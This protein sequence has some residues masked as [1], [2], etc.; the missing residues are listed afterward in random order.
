MAIRCMELGIP[1][2]IG[3]GEKKYNFFSKQNRIE[4]NCQ[5]KKIES[6]F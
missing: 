4:I 2:A 6:L 5:N 1:A 3:M